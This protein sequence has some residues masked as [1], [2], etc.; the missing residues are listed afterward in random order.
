MTVRQ[1]GFWM[2]I[3]N[4]GDECTAVQKVTYTLATL[5]SPWAKA[6]TRDAEESCCY[7]KYPC[8]LYLRWC[9]CW[10][11]IEVSAGLGGRRRCIYPPAESWAILQCFI[12]HRAA[13]SE[14]E[15]P[16][17]VSLQGESH[18]AECD[19]LSDP[20]RLWGSCDGW[21][22]VHVCLCEC[23]LCSLVETVA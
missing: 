15:T 14:G 22:N 13:Q 5:I 7:W 12:S 21:S 2:A 9:S 23:S 10:E 17:S 19:D 1:K 8:C 6:N 20:G 16:P 3:V 11:R 4:T 18:L